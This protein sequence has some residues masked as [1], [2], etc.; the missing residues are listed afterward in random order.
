MI[1]KQTEGYWRE[2]DNNTT[3]QDDGGP[4]VKDGGIKE[5]VYKAIMKPIALNANYKQCNK[6]KQ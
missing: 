6:R 3:E 4:G 2:E 5:Y 1:E